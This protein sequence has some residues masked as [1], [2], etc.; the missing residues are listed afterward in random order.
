M[1]IFTYGYLASL[2][3]DDDQSTEDLKAKLGKAKALMT[4]IENFMTE[5]LI[6]VTM[7][8]RLLGSLVWP[9]VFYGC[10]SWTSKNSDESRIN[11][12]KMQALMQLLLLGAPDRFRSNSSLSIVYCLGLARH[13]FSCRSPICLELFTC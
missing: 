1:D 10:E 4:K 9:V 2:F 13:A 7:K 8:V 5:S 11:S 3:T 6:A 12:F